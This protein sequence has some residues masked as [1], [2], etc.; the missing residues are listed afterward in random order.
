MGKFL[1][2]KTQVMDFKLTSYGKELLSIGQ[3]TPEFYAFFDDNVV[4]DKSYMTTGSS[5]I[6]TENQNDIVKRIKHETPYLETQVAFEDIQDNARYYSR[7]N[8]EV[9]FVFNEDYTEIIGRNS[10]V[11]FKPDSEPSSYHPTIDV[12]R[13]EQMIGDA[14]LDSKTRN[15]PSWKFVALKGEIKQAFEKS[16]SGSNGFTEDLEIPQINIDL[17]YRIKVK[18]INYF[19]L[20]LDQDL[21]NTANI[22]A[23]QFFDDGKYYE[24]E[25]DDLVFYLE[26]QNTILLNDNF[27]VEV[28]EFALEKDVAIGR[29]LSEAVLFPDSDFRLKS[30]LRRKTFDKDYKKL[31]GGL[32]TE[33]YLNNYDKVVFSHDVSN[34]EYYFDIYKD[35]YVDKH[36]ACKGIQIYNKESYYIDIDFDCSDTSTFENVY[37]DIYGPVTEPELCQ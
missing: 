22:A 28:F 35:S 11:S 25:H 2:K 21:L 12:Y 26:E 32:I 15:M 7:R 14:A 17:N 5:D 10:T 16:L 34:V 29:D 36:I 37:N 1:N 23:T 31:N 4:Y 30:V 24:L 18:D 33:E 9:E 3:F 8:E 19:D 20:S 6:L 13:H 27:D